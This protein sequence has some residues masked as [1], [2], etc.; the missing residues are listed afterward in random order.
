VLVYLA[1]VTTI[2][3]FSL[4]IYYVRGYSRPLKT[5]LSTTIG[6]ILPLE[7]KKGQSAVIG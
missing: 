7:S 5:R 1:L 2:L 4:P 6:P 3:L